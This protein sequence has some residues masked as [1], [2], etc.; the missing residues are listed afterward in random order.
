MDIQKYEEHIVC[1][2]DGQ[3]KRE[4]ER[5]VDSKQKERESK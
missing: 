5:A 1:A 3:K 4:R 2:R